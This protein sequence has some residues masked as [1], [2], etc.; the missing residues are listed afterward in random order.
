MAPDAGL[1]KIRRQLYN[2]ED[3]RTFTSWIQSGL[4]SME[5]RLEEG[6]AALQHL[7]LHL[8]NVACDDSGATIG[9]QLALPMLQERLEAK[10][11]KFAAELRNA[12]ME[13]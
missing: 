3:E 4:L 12:H 5:K 2:D 11:H 1:Q 9:A 6:R 7:E 10:A 13:V 8:I